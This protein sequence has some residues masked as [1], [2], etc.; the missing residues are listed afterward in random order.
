MENVTFSDVL[1]LSLGTD[2]SGD[3]VSVI[4]PRN[5]PFPCSKTKIFVTSQD[6]QSFFK[7]DVLQGDYELASQCHKIASTRLDGIPKKPKGQ[8]KISVTYSIDESGLL[9]VT[10]TSTNDTNIVVKLTVSEEKLNL[11]DD[12][13]TRAM[14][15]AEVERDA[16][17]QKKAI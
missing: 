10:A 3:R 1:P 2:I 6:N 16:D 7:L 14:Q 12:E 15:S 9:T 8:E 13:I 4:L 17:I 5:T 11:S